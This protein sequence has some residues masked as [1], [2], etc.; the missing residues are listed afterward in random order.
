LKPKTAQILVVL[1]D[2]HANKPVRSGN[3]I[4][5]LPNPRDYNAT[6]FLTYN[7]NWIYLLGLHLACTQTTL[8]V[9]PTVAFIYCA[10]LH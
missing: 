4:K 9:Q 1:Y 10:R 8:Q 5:Y 6:W 2:K 3:E 7:R